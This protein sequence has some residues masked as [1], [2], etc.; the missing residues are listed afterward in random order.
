MYVVLVPCCI[1]RR[2][3]DTCWVGES[4]QSLVENQMW[5]WGGLVPSGRVAGEWGSYLL[6]G[7]E[8]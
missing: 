8:V 7:W 2:F 5:A 3:L 4:R 1:L 6:W